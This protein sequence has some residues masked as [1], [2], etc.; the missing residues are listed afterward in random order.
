MKKIIIILGCIILGC[1]IFEMLLGDDDTSYKSVQK[2]L[3]QIQLNYY[4]EDY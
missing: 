4:Q 3:M 1:F 2:N